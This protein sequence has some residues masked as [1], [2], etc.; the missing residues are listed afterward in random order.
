MARL[1]NGSVVLLVL[2]NTNQ[3]GSRAALVGPCNGGYPQCHLA[4][5]HSKA[6]DGTKRRNV[7]SPRQP[8]NRATEERITIGTD[9]GSDQNKFRSGEEKPWVFALA[10]KYDRNRLG[11]T[12]IG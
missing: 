7:G 2:L 4:Q 9:F 6:C 12:N 11:R 5:G 1:Q 8:A 3:Y 10:R